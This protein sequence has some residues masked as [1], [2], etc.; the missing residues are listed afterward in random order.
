VIQCAEV[1]ENAPLVRDPYAGVAEPNLEGIGCDGPDKYG[2]PN[3]EQPPLEPTQTLDNGIKVMRFC[4]GLDAKGTVDFG[5][6]MYVFEG[7]LRMTSSN[8][9][10]QL[11]GDGVTFF[12][13]DGGEMRL[14]GAALD[15][16]APAT[17]PFAGLLVFGSRSATTAN[18]HIGGNNNPIL[19][20]AVYAPASA[21]TMS[22]NAEATGG[23]GCTRVIG[24]TV[25]FTGAGDAV[26]QTTTCPAGT[27]EII[28]N[29][30]VSL[31]E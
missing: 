2:K 19:T 27:S 31:V 28:T 4:S 5:P 17:G 3:S 12:F 25:T 8:P 29:E 30:M 22:G 18:H 21:I 1:K 7:T 13:P 23:G 20:G 14:T 15:L 26:L 11:A 9:A 16:A 6:G 24:D 10:S